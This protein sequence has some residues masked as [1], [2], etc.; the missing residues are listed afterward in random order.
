MALR[1][2]FGEVLA[3]S[4]SLGGLP[5]R[6]DSRSKLSSPRTWHHALGTPPEVFDLAELMQYLGRPQVRQ[7]KFHD[8]LGWAQISV[9]LPTGTAASDTARSA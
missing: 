2:T 1:Q 6:Q 8:D 4:R 5:L 3:L 7:R 9:P